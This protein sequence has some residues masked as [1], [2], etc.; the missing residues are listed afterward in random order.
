MPFREKLKKA[1]KSSPSSSKTSSPTISQT[2]Q[3]WP[4]NVYRPD[5]P[6]PRPKYRAP[7][8]KEHKEKL[9]SFNFG[10]SWRRRSHVSLYSPMGSRLPSRRGSRVSRQSVSGPS[11]AGRESL[12]ARRKS[13]AS[14]SRSN[15]ITGQPDTARRYRQS[16]RIAQQ[17]KLQAEPEHSGDDDV[18]NVGIS[19]VNSNE[20]PPQIHVN[21]PT[22][23]RTPATRTPAAIPDSSRVTHGNDNAYF[24]IENQHVRSGQ[25]EYSSS[26]SSKA[27]SGPAGQ[28]IISNLGVTDGGYTMWTDEELTKAMARNR[29]SS[30]AMPA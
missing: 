29:M 21:Q 30:Q 23:T 27:D 4:S 28:H 11:G 9:E 12:E 8:K 10:S 18:A 1:F 2:E 19:R 7:V 16:L 22:P 3:R 15:S 6:M 14:P 24:S 5:E 17:M 25:E 20:K 26:T 13:L